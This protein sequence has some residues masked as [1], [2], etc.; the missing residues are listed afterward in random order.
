MNVLGVVVEYNPLHMGHRGHLAKSQE[1]SSSDVVVAVMSGNF[2]QRGE[3]AIY[4]KWKRAKMALDA[5][6]DVVI[7]LPL[8]YA[9]ASAG[10]FAK[11]AVTLL[12]RTGIVD[13]MCFGSESADLGALER[14]A[15]G[16]LTESFEFKE[17]MKGYLGK[18]LSYPA[19]RARAG[20]D[21]F[22]S[23]IDTPNSP[24]LPNLPNS[25]NDILGVEYFKALM[26]LGSHIKP[27][28]VP[29]SEGSAMEIRKGIYEEA[30]KAEKAEKSGKSEDSSN[31]ACLDNLSK[32]FHYVLSSLRDQRDLQV[33][34]DVTEGVENRLIECARENELIS[35][36]IA[37]AKTK[38]YTYLRLQ[39]IVLHMILG[40]TSNAMAEYE[41]SGGPQYIRVLGFSERGVGLLGQLQ[42]RAQLPVVLNLQEAKLDGLAA[43]MLEDEIRSSKLYS[44]AF[45][46]H[47]CFNEYVMP[48]V[49]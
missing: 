18:G 48:L 47:C 25:P 30:E 41:M 32:V 24:N 8:Y 6:V 46:E 34:L 26:Q 9:T 39:R 4:D 28:T 44:L 11:A 23:A 16:L 45:R 21:A 20:A 42:Q 29:R 43:R 37:A 38:R 2:V 31:F 27:Y 5:G 1:I 14:Y 15:R 17:S 12:D 22:E 19:A 10:Y 3:P 35:D 49:R 40:I 33:Y 7:E 13:A 36:I